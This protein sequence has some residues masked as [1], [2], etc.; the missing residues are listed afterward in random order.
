VKTDYE[1][2]VGGLVHRALGLEVCGQGMVRNTPAGGT[3]LNK[4]GIELAKTNNGTKYHVRAD[5]NLE[6]RCFMF[7]F[8]FGTT[9]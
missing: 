9:K 8:G 6:K 1:S 7:G 2:G 4:L 5:Y 3:H